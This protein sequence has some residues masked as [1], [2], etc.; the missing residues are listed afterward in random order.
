[1]SIF[2]E[3]LEKLLTDET[4]EL[5]RSTGD[6]K[7]GTDTFLVRIG[8][9][10]FR[11]KNYI[12]PTNLVT[13]VNSPYNRDVNL[14]NIETV[15]D[16]LRYL[17]E[18]FS[19]C[20]KFN[21]LPV[22]Y[23]YDLPRKYRINGKIPILG[24]DRG[25]GAHFIVNMNHKYDVDIWEIVIILLD[26]NNCRGSN[27][28]REIRNN[29]ENQ[30]TSGQQR[31]S[32]RDVVTPKM[33]EE[34]NNLKIS[35]EVSVE[36]LD[37]H[38]IEIL[39]HNNKSNSWTIHRL[40]ELVLQALLTKD[41]DAEFNLDEMYRTVCQL[42]IF[43]GE[44]T[45]MSKISKVVN[46]ISSHE[47]EPLMMFYGAYLI[48]EQSKTLEDKRDTRYKVFEKTENAKLRTRM[49]KL[50]Y[51]N[52]TTT[53]ELQKLAREFDKVADHSKWSNVVSKLALI[54]D[55]LESL[56]YSGSTKNITDLDPRTLRAALRWMSMIVLDLKKD[57]KWGSDTSS[58]TELV[59]TT[60]L[61]MLSFSGKDPRENPVIDSL[62]KATTGRAAREKHFY[63]VLHKTCVN[64]Y[65]GESPARTSKRKKL[66]TLQ[67][68]LYDNGWD[69]GSTFSVIDRTRESAYVVTTI[70]LETGKG[71]QLG[72]KTAGAQTTDVNTFLQFEKDNNFNSAHDIEEGYW[73]RY[74]EAIQEMY[75]SGII[76]DED[77]YENTME[78][79]AI[80]AD[81]LI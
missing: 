14:F 69:R 1:M 70:N 33:L 26:Q 20:A 22:S 12:G 5:V 2:K 77:A 24:K 25:H 71:F 39:A 8:D 6:V 27:T 74:G 48:G 41:E 72:H 54:K 49:Y 53:A 68:Y 29:I 23:V 75:D 46:K 15:A 40:A 21:S 60:A 52:G 9:I 34:F 42:K 81:V 17:V 73:I 32:V 18:M 79:C 7:Y 59:I 65:K 61:D 3:G 19:G 13:I 30:I 51:E 43:R 31:F 47:H 11:E 16:K 50:I 37:N 4:I 78:F 64:K 58:L 63:S 56:N 44:K 35:V 36:S 57:L 55:K 76:T 62:L 80:M 10:D 45:L 66:T 38:Y 67:N 28:I